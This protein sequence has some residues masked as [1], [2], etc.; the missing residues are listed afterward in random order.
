MK[1][2]LTAGTFSLGILLPSIAL[3]HDGGDHVHG[4]LAGL[5]H[6]FLGMDHLLAMVAVGVIAAKIGGRSALLVSL[7]FVSAMVVG[8]LAGM[9]GLAL[10]SLEASIALSVVLLGVM[11]MFAG[12]LSLVALMALTGV[13]G[14]FHGNAHGLEVPETASGLAY[15]AGFILATLVLHAAG[16]L[17]GL[18]LA[19]WPAAIRVMGATTSLLGLGL[20]T[21]AI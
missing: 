19:Q 7:S 20:A 2:L 10:P 16:A 14:L 9:A 5:E 17:S 4:L 15:G 6:P 1:R 18:K 13:F 11:I 3:A 12:Q 8:A 21:Q